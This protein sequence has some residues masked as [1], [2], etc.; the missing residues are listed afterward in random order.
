MAQG[1]EI[2][3]QGIPV[4]HRSSNSLETKA[5]INQIPWSE[6]ETLQRLRTVVAEAEWPVF[7]TTPEF[8]LWCLSSTGLGSPT[9]RGKKQ[10][11]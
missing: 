7:Q 6:D 2:L 3:V 10:K 1:V 9:E 4:L 8:Q 5:N 11:R